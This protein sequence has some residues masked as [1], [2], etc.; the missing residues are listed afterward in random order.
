MRP[1]VGVYIANQSVRCYFESLLKPITKR[2]AEHS[3][4]PHH[5]IVVP[6]FA[7][8]TNK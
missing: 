7:H 8:E 6:V 2:L 4:I 3:P 1:L 5:K